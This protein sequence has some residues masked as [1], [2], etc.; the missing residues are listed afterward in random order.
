METCGTPMGDW[1]EWGLWFGGRGETGD[2]E[3]VAVMG[4]GQ[5]GQR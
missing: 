4:A 5:E 3:R 2:D 1:I